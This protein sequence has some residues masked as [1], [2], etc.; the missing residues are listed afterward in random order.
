MNKQELA[1][2]MRKGYA[3]FHLAEYRYAFLIRA[4]LTGIKNAKFCACPLGSAIVAKLG[5]IEEAEDL[6]SSTGNIFEVIA[7]ELKIS[8]KLA[9]DI[10]H[11]HAGHW[12]SA[13]EIIL[14]L[15]NNK[16]VFE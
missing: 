12:Q 5:S 2:L 4:D 1:K 13:K 11:A 10:S 8:P 7:D 3:E 14:A 15:E 16:F 9:A 6:L